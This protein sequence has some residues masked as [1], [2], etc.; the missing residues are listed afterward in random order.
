MHR[1]KSG[2][3]R[4]ELIPRNFRNKNMEKIEAKISA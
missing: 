1:N 3:N 2:L 4:S